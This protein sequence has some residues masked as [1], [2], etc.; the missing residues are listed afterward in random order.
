MKMTADDISTL[1]RVAQHYDNNDVW[2]KEKWRFKHS[3][4]IDKGVLQS[5]RHVDV[6]EKWDGWQG[7]QT[8][9]TWTERGSDYIEVCA[10]SAVTNLSDEQLAAIEQHADVLLEVYGDEEFQASD[11]NLIGQTLQT[12]S[13]ADVLLQVESEAGAASTWT[14]NPTVEG[15]IA[16]IQ[17][18]I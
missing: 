4:T 6:I 3:D 1:A 17:T 10:S 5:L 15:V 9:W 7:S 16:S 11:Y 13:Q 12:L 14:V 18:A 2:E 8:T